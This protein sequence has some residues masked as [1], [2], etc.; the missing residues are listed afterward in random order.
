[1]VQNEILL[2]DKFDN[3]GKILSRGNYYIFV[4]SYLKSDKISLREISRPL[5]IVED[6]IS[7][8]DSLDK[9]KIS[10]DLVVKA[11]RENIQLSDVLSMIEELDLAE[12][13]THYLPNNIKELLLKYLIKA[14]LDKKDDLYKQY[15]NDSTLNLKLNILYRND[16]VDFVNKSKKDTIFGYFL[17]EGKS[18]RVMEFIEKENRFKEATGDDKKSVI[19][20]LRRTAQKFLKTS[21]VLSYMEMKKDTPVLK[22]MDTSGDQ[23]KS[24]KNQASGIVL[25]SQGMKKTPLKDYIENLLMAREFHTSKKRYE[26]GFKS[27]LKKKFP[28]INAELSNFKDKGKMYEVVEDLFIYNNTNKINGLKWFFTLEEYYMSKL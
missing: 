9:I 2:R 13:R 3:V 19:N 5:E 21:P 10:R 12:G 26:E 7:L 17:V 1:M 14:G 28:K 16:T 6:K 8:T 24:K 4:P 18:I 11:N 25:K 15:F 23:G 27:L 20:Y 22:V